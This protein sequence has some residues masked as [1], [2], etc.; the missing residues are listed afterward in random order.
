MIIMTHSAAPL[1]FPPA[2]GVLALD[3]PA[4]LVADLPAGAVVTARFADLDAALLARVRPE[5]VMLP[6]LSPDHDAMAVVERL[7]SLGYSGRITV[8]ARH[9]PNARMVEAEL[10]A[11]GPGPRLTLLAP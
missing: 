9:L 1:P 5:Q 11:L 8:V 7:Q 10:R 2:G 6:L 4:P 3:L